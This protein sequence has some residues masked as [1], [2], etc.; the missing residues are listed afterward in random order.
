MN[1]MSLAKERCRYRRTW[2][3]G[4][5]STCFNIGSWFVCFRIQY[6]RCALHSGEDLPCIQVSGVPRVLPVMSLQHQG[7]ASSRLAEHSP[8]TCNNAYMA[9]HRW[10]TNELI[11]RGV[12]SVCRSYASKV[13]HIKSCATLRGSSNH[14]P[15]RR[16]C[17]AKSLCLVDLNHL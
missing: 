4:C 8:T 9:W 15:P 16:S 2:R 11:W 14:K 1:E 12:N 17:R 6:Y 10:T 5:R 3:A 13:R 7:I